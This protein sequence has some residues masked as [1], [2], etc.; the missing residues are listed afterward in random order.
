MRGGRPLFDDEDEVDR[1]S[2]TPT[3]LNSHSRP[4]AVTGAVSPPQTMHAITSKGGGKGGGGQQ[5]SFGGQV[6][7][8]KGRQSGPKL[9]GK[10]RRAERKGGKKGGKR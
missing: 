5:A 3:P 7:P 8:D 6:Q 2:G 4:K 10:A 1:F 9:S